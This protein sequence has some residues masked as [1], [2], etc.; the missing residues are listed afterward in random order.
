MIDKKIIQIL[1]AG[2]IG[3]LATDTLY[4]LVGQALSKESI[5]RIYRVRH[6]A[7]KKS[8]IVLISSLDDL[9]LFNIKI[10]SGI[11]KQLLKF[12]PGKVS[13]I[14]PCPDKKFQYLHRGVKTLAFRLSKKKSLINLVKKTGPL[15]APSANL[16]GEPPAETIKQAKKYFGDKIDFYADSGKISGR[17]STLIKIEKGKMIILRKG[18]GRV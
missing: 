4:G 12:W 2:G 9:K 3:V 17:P 18:A 7:P 11:K 14:L 10:N 15:V 16:E 13:I 1:N 5:E 6:R 8:S